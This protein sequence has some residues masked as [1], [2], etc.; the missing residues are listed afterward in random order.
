MKEIVYFQIDKNQNKLYFIQ[1]I[2]LKKSIT[3]NMFKN[4]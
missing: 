2:K 4:N 3:E 1:I